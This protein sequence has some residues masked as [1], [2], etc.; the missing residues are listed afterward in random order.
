MMLDSRMGWTLLALLC[1]LTLGSFL[2]VVIHRLPRMARGRRL[3]RRYNLAWPRSHCPACRQTLRVRH[4]LP[5]FSWLCLRGRCAYCQARISLRYPLV[6]VLCAA[7][8]ALLTWS[9]PSLPWLA[10]GLVY[11]SVLIA[12]AFIDL[13]TGLLPDGLTLPLLWAGLLFHLDSR[14]LP[15]ADAVLGAVAGYLLPW[16]I[17]WCYRLASGKEG[18]GYGDFKLL[19]A[20]GAWLGWRALPSLLLISSLTGLAVAGIL[21]L[22]RRMS[23]HDALPF[24]PFLALSGCLAWWWGR[25]F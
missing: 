21:M 23:R 12:L 1:G 9:A 2:N 17:Y 3:V 24:G 6:E 11:T 14:S 8:F 20:L 18:L 4:L 7:S 19:A 22:S 10:G 15:L 25:A 5:V 16:G 13:E